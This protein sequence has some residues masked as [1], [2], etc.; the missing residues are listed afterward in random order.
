LPALADGEAVECLEHEVGDG[1]ALRIR[2]H[3]VISE[4]ISLAI[5]TVVGRGS[6][7]PALRLLLSA[8]SEPSREGSL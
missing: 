5:S 2:R 3:G 1:V 7:D 4:Q 6:A 8:A